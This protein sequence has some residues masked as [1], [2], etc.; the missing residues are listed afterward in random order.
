MT[1]KSH[2]SAIMAHAEIGIKI[3]GLTISMCTGGFT[4][5]GV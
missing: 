2:K 3:V 4:G 5:L 1:E